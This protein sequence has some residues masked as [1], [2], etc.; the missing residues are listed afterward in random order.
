MFIVVIVLKATAVE[1][2][3]WMTSFV[4]SYLEMSRDCVPSQVQLRLDKKVMTRCQTIRT[5]Q[6]A[7]QKN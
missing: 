1:A 7:Q 4:D 2:A 6:E 3:H 5:I